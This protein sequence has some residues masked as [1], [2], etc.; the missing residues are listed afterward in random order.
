MSP[1]QNATLNPP[2]FAGEGG[3]RS[4]PGEGSGIGRGLAPLPPFAVAKG[5]LPRR[6][7]RGL[8]CAP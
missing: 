8:E 3:E 6:G 7:G 4:E 2:P 1:T 5:A